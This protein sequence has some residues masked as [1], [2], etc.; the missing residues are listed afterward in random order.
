MTDCAIVIFKM[1]VISGVKYKER[2]IM[3]DTIV[4]YRKHIAL[5]KVKSK[6]YSNRNLRNKGIE[7]FQEKL[8]EL[9]SH[10]T[11]DDEMKKK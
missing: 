8:K 7:E 6:E 1:I 2:E 11:W 5:W 3:M 4:V 9:H 10:C